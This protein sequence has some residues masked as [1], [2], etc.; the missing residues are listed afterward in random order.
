MENNTRVD[1]ELLKINK[2]ICRHIDN[3]S[4]ESRPV[5]AQD[6]ISDLRHLVDHVRVK[7]YAGGE[8]IEPNYDAICKARKHVE[9]IA[10]Y[11]FINRF[12]DLLEMVVS[13]Y[14][15]DEDSAERL[16]LKYYSSLYDI[17]A[18]LKDKYD[19]E[20]I[21]NLEKFP[22]DTDPKLQEYYEKISLKI[23]S[24]PIFSRVQKGNRYYIQKI[25]PFFV[26]GKK[27]YELAFSEANDRSIK[28][29][30]II[31]FSKIKISPN[32]ACRFI[33]QVS[34]IDILGKKMP[35]TI[36]LGW[37][38]AIRDCEFKNFGCVV[39]GSKSEVGYSESTSLCRYLTEN[40][41]TLVDVVLFTEEEYST[42][43]NKVFARAQVRTL[44]SV[45]DKCREIV[46]KHK[47]GE[48]VIRLLL[49]NMNNNLIK[50][51]YSDTANDLLSH[52]YLNKGCIPFDRIP[53]NFSPINHNI[54][55]SELLECIEYKDKIAQLFARH[56]K[57]NS[58]TDGMLFTSMKDLEGYG[59][60]E[61]LS[62]DYNDSLYFRHKPQAEIR[63][64][65]GHAFIY[66]YVEDCKYIVDKIRELTNE[67]IDDF[68]KAMKSWLSRENSGNDCEEKK[69][70]L[71]NIFS[72]SK[73]GIVYGAAGTGKT[74]FIKH[75]SQYFYDK[76]KLFLAQTNPAVDNLRRKIDVSKCEFSTIASYL[77][78]SYV[79]T[80]YDIIIIDE[81]STV[82]N[83]DMRRVL[84]K[85]KFNVL[86]LVGDTYQIASIRF[87]NWFSIIRQ[88]LPTTAVHELTNTYRSN[89]TKL[90]ELW[91]RV[92][93]MD[94]SVE[95]MI[96]RPEFSRRLDAT[97]FERSESDE[98]ILCLNY[99][100][101]YGINNINRF[102]QENN[103]GKVYEWGLKQYRVGDPI[104]FNESERF[105]PVIYN[106]M[107][108]IIRGIDLLQD[109]RWGESIV[110]DIE[111]DK[112]ING[113]DALGKDFKICHDYDTVN[114]VVRFSVF[115]RRSEDDDDVD[116][117]TIVPFQIA[118][119]VSIHKAQGLEYDSVK[120]IITNEVE[121]KITHNIFYT[122]ITRARKN[123]RI[124]WSPEVQ[125]H[126]L[127]SIKPVDNGKDVVLLKK[128][129]L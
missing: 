77:A 113:L 69:A 38:I 4:R 128:V 66:S 33:T 45:L 40:R 1:K 30:R 119:A 36:I 60:A 107:K 23:E 70:I 76:T 90:R 85:V 9:K 42:F 92:R 81:C 62:K 20:I 123:L 19:F 116:S 83:T 32:Y 65:N 54:R 43:L 100:G 86:L 61:E 21:H 48:N 88:F 67:G 82:S 95:E 122:A 53:F 24:F 46:T 41:L 80:Q 14:K 72:D 124:Y 74:T 114:S 56:I 16:M 118:Y 109:E 25:K 101:L 106:N 50:D 68:S 3:I 78:S 79:E 47:H 125:E 39:T 89:D 115:K 57:S 12:Y 93:E 28:T 71:T 8:D 84:D 103:P 126:I 99:D 127:N 51:Q 59:N 102:L 55:Y 26:N 117:N 94:G 34:E 15:P 112:V 10:Q 22:L 11:K 97:I 108:G 7:I 52:L 104:L 110:F 98:I 27:Y 73:V 13:H 58:E 96:S 87:G 121:E 17:R 63:I 2:S 129:K 111:L 44:L 105:A 49:N 5:V 35:I 31:A 120:I 18:F 37:E 75:L 6:V 29:D 64:Q 91:R